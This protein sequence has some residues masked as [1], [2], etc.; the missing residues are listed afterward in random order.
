MKTKPYPFTAMFGIIS[1]LTTLLVCALLW[2]TQI[3]IVETRTIPMA[4]RPE[5]V[6]DPII[7]ISVPDGDID[8]YEFMRDVYD[9][10]Y[11]AGL[12][13]RE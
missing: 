12:E 3:E 7:K 6:I 10:G 9:Q 1:G 13:A 8:L 5:I 2:N 11:R 4:T